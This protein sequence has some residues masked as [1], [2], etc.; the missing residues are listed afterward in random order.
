MFCSNNL[1]Y[2]R[3]KGFPSF[4][5]AQN[6]APFREQN[7][8]GSPRSPAKK[9]FVGYRTPTPCEKIFVGC[10]TPTPCGKTFVGRRLQTPCGG[11]VLVAK[12]ISL[13]KGRV[14]SKETSDLP[15]PKKKKR[16]YAQAT[17][18]L[19][20]RRPQ[21]RFFGKFFRFSLY[22][23]DIRQKRRDIFGMVET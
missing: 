14:Q 18:A 17:A 12:I 8:I 19:Q 2:F 7:P 5:K 3:Q 16:A 23:G 6:L 10:R 15:P 22:F 13:F 9:A 1:G 4:I 11:I 20:I 21:K